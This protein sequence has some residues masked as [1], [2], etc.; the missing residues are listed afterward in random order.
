MPV[1]GGPERFLSNHRWAG[2]DSLVWL[3]DCKGLIVS[4]V[5]ALYV[6]EKQVANLLKRSLRSGRSSQYRSW[7]SCAKTSSHGMCGL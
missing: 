3:S 2:I 6:I 7:P 4:G 1:N 5:R